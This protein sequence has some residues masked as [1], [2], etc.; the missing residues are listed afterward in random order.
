M[1]HPLLT[2]GRRP[3]PLSSNRDR[4]GHNAF[5]VWPQSLFMSRPHVDGAAAALTWLKAAVASP[6][7]MACGQP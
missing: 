2:N 6:P 3:S 1:F 4:P 5:P 7:A